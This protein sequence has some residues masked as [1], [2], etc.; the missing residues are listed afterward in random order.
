MAQQVLTITQINEYIRSMMDGDGLLLR[1]R[2]RSAITKY[3]PP[4]I[5]TSL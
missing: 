1:S 3:T 4:A 2:V 5:I